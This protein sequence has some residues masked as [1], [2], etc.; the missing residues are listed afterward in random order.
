MMMLVLV[1]MMMTKMKDD[2]HLRLLFW[3]HLEPV[4]DA[5][6]VFEPEGSSFQIHENEIKKVEFETQSML[7]RLEVNFEPHEFQQP[8]V[9]RRHLAH[10]KKSKKQLVDVNCADYR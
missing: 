6:K 1:L 9:V 3:V 10:V 7:Q 5:E 2:R 4:L 8:T